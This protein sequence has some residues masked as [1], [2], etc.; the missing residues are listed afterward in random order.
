M[1]LHRTIM[2]ATALSLG[3]TAAHA[4][5]AH[6]QLRPARV[7]AIEAA[8]PIIVSGEVAGAAAVTP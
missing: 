2:L 5:L 1:R 7:V 4:Q 6:A 8:V 3:A